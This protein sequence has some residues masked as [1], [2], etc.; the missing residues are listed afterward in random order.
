MF[1]VCQDLPS[2]PG[3]QS[4]AYPGP[5][6]ASYKSF[7]FPSFPDPG[8]SS[9]VKLIP[10]P[11]QSTATQW[12][13]TRT[14]SMSLEAKEV[15]SRSIIKRNLEAI[16]QNRVSKTC[17]NPAKKSCSGRNMA[18]S[19]LPHTAVHCRVTFRRVF[20]RVRLSQQHWNSIWRLHTWS[21]EAVSYMDSLSRCAHTVLSF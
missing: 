3:L 6:P 12:Y 20:C 8:P 13:H 11:M 14:L 19:H 10:F 9:G 5:H 17:H 2:P 15:T 1:S 16:P 18:C 4:T 21:W 7:F